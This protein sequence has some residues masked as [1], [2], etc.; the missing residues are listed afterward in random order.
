[1]SVRQY[2]WA[3]RRPGLVRN[4]FWLALECVKSHLAEWIC[5]LIFGTLAHCEQQL[6]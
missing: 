6:A 1:M 4:D 2:A 3:H 5:L